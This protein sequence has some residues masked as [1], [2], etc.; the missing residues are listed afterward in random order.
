MTKIL[1][2]EKQLQILSKQILNEQPTNRPSKDNPLEMDCVSITGKDRWKP[3]G[4]TYQS[5]QEYNG[6]IDNGGEHHTF[7]NQNTSGPRDGI[8]SGN[9]EV[10]Q[11]RTRLVGQDPD[12]LEDIEKIP[13][14]MN[15]S[16][17]KD[18]IINVVYRRGGHLYFCN[19]FAKRHNKSY[20]TGTHES[21]K[22]YLNS[23]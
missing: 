3:W 10:I 19:P 6:G 9:D 15:L 13:S 21:W 14:D 12:I 16:I 11:L 17:D 22:T 2:T 5:D 20:G 1:I 18:S 4:L 7:L 8:V 23:L